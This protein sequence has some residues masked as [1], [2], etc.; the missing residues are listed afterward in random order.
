MRYMLG[1][2]FVA[3]LAGAAF[4]IVAARPA[5]TSAA[6]SCILSVASAAFAGSPWLEL[7]QATALAFVGAS[8]L[9]GVESAAVRRLSGG[10]A[11]TQDAGHR[12]IRETIERGRKRIAAHLDGKAPGV[13]AAF[14][15]LVRT[16]VAI[17]ASDIHLSPTPDALSITCRVEGTLYEII[18]LPPQLAPRMV[19][20]A[21]VLARL[22][23]HI[24]GVPQD[25]RMVLFL[26]GD[27]L[28]ARVSSLPTDSGERV[29]LRLVRGSRRVPK[30][31]TLGLHPETC[32]RLMELLGHAQGLLFV[33]GVVG[34]GK[35]TTLYAALQHIASTRGRTTSIVT[36][37]DPIELELPF[38]TQTQMNTKTGMNFAGTLRSVLRQDPNVLMVGEIRDR[39]TADI[40]VQAGL[41]GHLIL[42]T[43]H[44]DT[45]AGPFARL[46]E[47][48]VEPFVLASAA[49]GSLS[50][51][52][53]RTLCTACRRE[54][55]PEPMIREAYEKHGIQL[56]QACYFEPVGCD[57]CE[58]LGFAGR[59]PIAELLIVGPDCRKAIHDRRPTNEIHEIA[60]AHGM[61]NLLR[62]GLSRAVAGETSLGEV[63]R[64]A[65]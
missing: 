27:K 40:V 36:L 42:T 34:S 38:A 17:A 63:L 31:E 13:V 39:E 32:N 26:D 47:L 30:L 48:D 6:G 60:V 37:E 10:S 23:T 46:V 9:S 33:T 15:E 21:K 1:L 56:P 12:S 49:I 50:Q 45:A 51:R 8:V 25:G 54:A 44:A 20:R 52:L 65:G 61:V 28:E 57:Y 58:G 29:V 62:D 24:R 18:T 19:V 35:T 4:C 59:V 5:D 11:A 55:V 53:V 14:D 43:V 41:T 22:D 16:A 3:A 64:V 7:L 2:L